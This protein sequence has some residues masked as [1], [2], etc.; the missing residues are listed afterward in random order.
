MQKQKVEVIT[1]QARFL[2]ERTLFVNCEGEN[3]KQI[4]FKQAIIATGSSIIKIPAYLKIHRI[5]RANAY[6]IHVQPC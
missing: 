4:K 2:N 5:K 1:G 3:S 6:L